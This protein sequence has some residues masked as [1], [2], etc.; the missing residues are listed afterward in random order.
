MN[1]T[2][3]IG[4]FLL[5]L[6]LIEGVYFF[7]RTINNPEKKEVLK[8]LG[9]ISKDESRVI[10]I[11]R[12]KVLSEVPWINRILTG[13]PWVEKFNRILEQANIQYPVGFFIIL[14]LLLALLT[15]LVCSRVFLSHLVSIIFAIIIAIL[16]YPYVYSRKDRRMK[17]FE[18]Q[19]PDAMDLIARSLR[20][21]H[22]FSS[23]LKMVADE[24]DDPIGIEFYKTLKE[25]NFGVS[26]PEALTNLADRVDCSDLKFFVISVILQRE[27]GGNL[28]EILEN[29]ARLIRE[30]FKLH[31][32][33][34]ILS[35]EG[36]FSATVL[37]ILPFVIALYIYLVNREYIS[38]L[39]EDP[40]GRILTIVAILMMFAGIL[41]MKRMIT[42]RV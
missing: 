27:T 39:V 24:F 28:A 19:L 18:R 14:S 25:I 16:P 2:L 11:T 20:A 32:R 23:G 1:L 7:Y 12:K 35:A 9:K 21:G 34:R 13:R 15:Y 37:V 33:V 8:R 6:L 29:I 38:I 31:G 17:K 36:K 26:V 5:F 22:A 40:I 10:D 30:R 3:G 41:A 42:I 4:I